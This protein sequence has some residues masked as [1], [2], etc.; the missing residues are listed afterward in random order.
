[1]GKLTID[2]FWLSV[3]LGITAFAVSSWAYPL[4]LR[5][6]RVWKVYDKPNDRKLH[7]KPIPVM[8]GLAVFIGILICT[9]LVLSIWFSWRQTLM[10][11]STAF[12]FLIGTID[13]IK[14]LGAMVRLIIETAIVTCMIYV[15]GNMIDYFGGIFGIDVL[16]LYVSYPLSV[17]AGVGIINAIN[18]IDG[19]NGYSSGYSIM[20]CL[21]FGSIF[22]LSGVYGLTFVCIIVAGSLLPFLLHNVFG[23]RTQMFIGNGGALMVGTILTSLVFST[24]RNKSMCHEWSTD[25]NIC[26]VALTV[27]MLSIAIF[28]TLRVMLTRI[29]KGSSPF[30]ADKTH[31]HHLFIDFGFSHFGTTIFII[32]LN[33]MVVASWLICWMLGGNSTIQFIVV[34]G[35]SLLV[36]FI[37]YPFMRHQQAKNSSVC[38]FMNKLGESTHWEKDK[39]WLW[40]QRFIDDELFSDGK[41]E[42]F[43]IEENNN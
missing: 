2:Y 30:H 8:G 22:Y 34:I 14:G 37:F 10:V 42:H 4:V 16:P 33:L 39:W 20:A 40:M 25:N 35:G 11:A 9:S 17:I 7:H 36:T 41:D 5:M 18:L 3:I 29:C 19:V 13:D 6:A 21:C 12:L 43:F 15:S 23:V 31:L 24:L 32:C 27:A 26:L 1:M 28:D 38:R